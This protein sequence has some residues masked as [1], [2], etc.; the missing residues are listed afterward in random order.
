[1]TK[2]PSKL[3]MASRSCASCLSISRTLV[4]KVKCH[5][6]TIKGRKVLVLYLE[7]H[8][9]DMIQPSG[10]GRVRKGTWKRKS[11]HLSPS[12]SPSRYEPPSA[13]TPP[14][15]SPSTHQP[16]LLLRRMLIQWS[17]DSSVMFRDC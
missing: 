3:L 16:A 17:F 7:H 6:Y 10:K 11:V 8:L 15:A 13:I 4:F 12:F 2:V 5:V 1:M 9:H 14:H